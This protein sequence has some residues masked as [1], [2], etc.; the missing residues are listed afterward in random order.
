MTAGE[1]SRGGAED[2]NNGQGRGRQ[3]VGTAVAATQNSGGGV[4]DMA[5]ESTKKHAELAPSIFH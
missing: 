4:E 1:D 3:Q 2:G 5:R